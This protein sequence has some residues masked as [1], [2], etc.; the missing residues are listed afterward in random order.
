MVVTQIVEKVSEEKEVDIEQ[1]TP[2]TEVIDGDCLRELFST[3][4][5]NY[6]ELIFEYEGYIVRIANDAS[7]TLIPSDETPFHD[8]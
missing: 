6:R 3:P 2:L 8:Q 7:V 5:E 4:T 1:L